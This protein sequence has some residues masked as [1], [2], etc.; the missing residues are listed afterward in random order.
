MPYLA[1][2]LVSQYKYNSIHISKHRSINTKY[3]MLYI[4]SLNAWIAL[5]VS[6]PI[7]LSKAHKQERSAALLC[8]NCMCSEST[9]FPLLQSFARLR[10]LSGCYFDVNSWTGCSI[11]PSRSNAKYSLQ[12]R[13]LRRCSLNGVPLSLKFGPTLCAILFP[14]STCNTRYFATRRNAVSTSHCTHISISKDRSWDM[15]TRNK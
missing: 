7:H 3:K 15:S 14:V 9:T 13:E 10:K 8:G 4:L 2:V 11:W 6:M 12:L 1:L 5:L